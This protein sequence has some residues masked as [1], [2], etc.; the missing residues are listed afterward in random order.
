MLLLSGEFSER[1]GRAR[2]GS[3]T[4][5]AALVEEKKSRRATT[6]YLLRSHAEQQAQLIISSGRNSIV[7][8]AYQVVTSGNLS[9]HGWAA[10]VHA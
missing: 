5:L 2:E 9:V 1:S 10:D 7:V 3:A 6:A 8:A 4:R